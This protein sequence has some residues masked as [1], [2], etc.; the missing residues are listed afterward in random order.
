M[1]KAVFIFTLW[2]K[3]TQVDKS[4]IIVL[5]FIVLG[6]ISVGLAKLD[7]MPVLDIFRN[8]A[9]MLVVGYSF[10]KDSSLNLNSLSDGEYFALLFTRPIKR[11]SYIL[12]KAVVTAL[13]IAA[14]VSGG[15]LICLLSQIVTGAEKIVFL[16]KFELLSVFANCWSFGCLMV[17]LRAL[18][19]KISNIAFVMFVYGCAGGSALNFGAKLNFDLLPST[20]YLW[21]TLCDIVQ[22]FF[23]PALDVEVALNSITFDPLPVVSYVSNC[24]IY[25]LAATLL[26]NRREFSYVQT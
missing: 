9:F 13:G 22:Q 2:L 8:P 12:T 26:V 3:I 11:S 16:D 10:A 19:P 24:L 17:F 4:D 6:C 21:G 15:L 20:I 1:N 5:A 18:P 7:Y 14:L 25:L 23:Y